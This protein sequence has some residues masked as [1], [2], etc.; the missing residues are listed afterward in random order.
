MNL[1]KKV[2]LF[3]KPNVKGLFKYTLIGTAL[4]GLSFGTGF[5]SDTKMDYKVPI[6]SNVVS[7]QKENDPIGDQRLTFLVETFQGNEVYL[8]IVANGESVKKESINAIEDWDKINGGIKADG[9]VRMV[10]SELLD[11]TILDSNIYPYHVEIKVADNPEFENATVYATDLT[12]PTPIFARKSPE[13]VSK[14]ESLLNKFFHSKEEFIEEHKASFKG[15]D[16]NAY[17][18]WN[19]SYAISNEFDGK[20]KG[21]IVRFSEKSRY[22]GGHILVSS[23]RGHTLL[24]LGSHG[25]R[26]NDS[27]FYEVVRNNTDLPLDQFLKLTGIEFESIEGKEPLILVKTPTPYQLFKK[28]NESLDKETYLSYDDLK[29]KQK[30]NLIYEEYMITPLTKNSWGEIELDWDKNTY[31]GA[32]YLY[33][34]NDGE[35]STTPV[36]EF[37]SY[38]DGSDLI[39][40]GKETGNLLAIHTSGA[41]I[42]SGSLQFLSEAK[43]KDAIHV[44]EGFGKNVE[45]LSEFKNL[46]SY[47]KE[48]NLVIKDLDEFEQFIDEAYSRYILNENQ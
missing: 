22:Q 20:N 47:E 19:W 6:I 25:P 40:I 21:Y 13:T 33:Y 4:V 34:D 48:K 14:F 35:F 10:L 32:S 26:D 31:I 45:T 7:K 11:T 39:L 15:G 5:A 28:V 1:D 43:N 12:N 46:Q 36:K 38:T 30:I 23:D 3:Y 42:E 41:D 17:L 44:A 27:W 37:H 8:D 24:I 16:C 9:G 29:I 18:L 2:D